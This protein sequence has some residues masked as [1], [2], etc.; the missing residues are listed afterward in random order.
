MLGC[1][2]CACACVG[3]VESGV[4]QVSDCRFFKFPRI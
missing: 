3:V 2:V 1:F 4:A